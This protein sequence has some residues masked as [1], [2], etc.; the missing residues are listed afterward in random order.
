[1]KALNSRWM[2]RPRSGMIVKDE[3]LLK[4]S[5]AYYRFAHSMVGGRR[6]NRDQIM[7]G[8][9]W[10]DADVFATIRH[11]AARSGSHLSDA[12]RRDLAIA[13][14]WQGKVDIVVRGLLVAPLAAYVGTG[15]WQVFEHDDPDDLPAW[16]P[17]AEAVQLYVPGLRE[18]NPATGHPIYRDA[19]AQ[20]A[21]QR[22]GWG[23]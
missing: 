20:M 21:Q 18:K 13:R 10:V 5:H 22:I 8:A 1:M 19:F 17:A 16:I 6:Q 23:P 14:R 7:G 12:A 15:S 4:P 11:K 9:W 2:Q 3:V